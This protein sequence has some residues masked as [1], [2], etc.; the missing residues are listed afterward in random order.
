MKA[1]ILEM[2]QRIPI[3]AGIAEE[4]LEHILDKAR[5]VSCQR[6]EFFFCQ[7]DRA[8][9]MFVLVDG[10]ATVVKSI[11]GRDYELSHLGTGDCFGELELIDLRPRA[12]SVRTGNSTRQLDVEEAM[13]YIKRRWRVS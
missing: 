1:L 8:E 9:S 4:A 10:Q 13:Q 11:E 5:D 3:F 12:A 2:L 6:C 7:E